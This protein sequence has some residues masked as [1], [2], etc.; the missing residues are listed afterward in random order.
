M[1]PGSRRPK[2]SAR[3][4]QRGPH[5]FGARWS[6]VQFWCAFIFVGLVVFLSGWSLVDEL[7]SHVGITL[8]VAVVC[9]VIAGRVGDRAWTWLSECLRWP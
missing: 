7:W 6:W 2:R 1:G 3:P 9:G 4:F 5:T 8:A